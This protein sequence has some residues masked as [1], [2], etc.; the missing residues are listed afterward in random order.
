[1]KKKEITFSIESSPKIKRLWRSYHAYIQC[2][3]CSYWQ[4]IKVTHVFFHALWLKSDYGGVY[5][6]LYFKPS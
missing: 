3:A 2:C 5:I 6:V 4:C 1:M